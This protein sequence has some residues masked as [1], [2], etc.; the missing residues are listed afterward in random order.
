MEQNWKCR[1]SWGTQNRWEL[2]KIVPSKKAT[3]FV[4][5]IGVEKLHSRGYAGEVTPNTPWFRKYGRCIYQK[6]R[7]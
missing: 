5:K 2:G 1:G 7:F 3:K 4:G 6:S